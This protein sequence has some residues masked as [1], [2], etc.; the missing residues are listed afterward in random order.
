MPD[1]EITPSEFT[2]V[3]PICNQAGFAKYLT[4]GWKPV[5]AVG[6]TTFTAANFRSE[7][8]EYAEFEYCRSFTSQY[9]AVPSL[10]F[11]DGKP[12]AEIKLG[13]ESHTQLPPQS[14]TLELTFENPVAHSV[15]DD[16]TFTLI[17]AVD[18]SSSVEDSFTLSVT[19]QVDS[20]TYYLNST[21]TLGTITYSNDQIASIGRV[22]VLPIYGTS[23]A[24]R[25]D[26]DRV[27]FEEEDPGKEGFKRATIT[28]VSAEVVAG[29][30]CF[31]ITGGIL[32]RRPDQLT[33][34]SLA[35]GSSAARLDCDQQSDQPR[36][37][38]AEL[39]FNTFADDPDTGPKF[40]SRQLAGNFTQ[41]VVYDVALHEFGHI[42]QQLHVD[43]PN[44]L[45][46]PSTYGASD[47]TDAAV[48]CGIHVRNVG[49]SVSDMC[50]NI[51]SADFIPKSCGTSPTKEN[52]NN[53]NGINMFYDFNSANLV[54]SIASSS[55]EDSVLSV[56][57]ATGRIV[58]TSTCTFGENRFSLNSI[59]KGFYGAILQGADFQIAKSFISN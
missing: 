23:N 52:E 8:Q 13:Y 26:L 46:F 22:E 7:M 56:A 25:S 24:N 31:N 21:A 5:V 35:Q 1:D 30:R 57:D 33:N 4:E 34:E 42:L 9:V 12:Q 29:I 38:F 44:E 32:P 14:M 28:S 3:L 54:V 2:S 48:A 19:Y 47:V 55:Y 37:I 53:V 43:D 39:L 49:G 11:A 15:L 58:F 41:A 51:I 20:F 6:N 27:V 18:F 40:L 10:V 59:P 17:E 36:V 50:S 45:M 16:A